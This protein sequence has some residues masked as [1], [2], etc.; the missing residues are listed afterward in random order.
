MGWES[1][2]VKEPPPFVQEIA[3]GLLALGDRPRVFEVNPVSVVALEEAKTTD[4]MD[5]QSKD[6]ARKFLRADRGAHG[7]YVRKRI[8]EEARA[9][10]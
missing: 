5:F 6:S 9:N 7:L 1:P 2:K 4:L 10:W 8:A 3:P